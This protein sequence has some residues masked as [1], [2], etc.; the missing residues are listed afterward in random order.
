MT[1][2]TQTLKLCGCEYFRTVW[3]FL[4][5]CS[6][7]TR[8]LKCLVHFI[9]LLIIEEVN[10]NMK[11]VFWG[12]LWRLQ[13]CS[14]YFEL[15]IFNKLLQQINRYEWIVKCRTLLYKDFELKFKNLFENSNK[16]FINYIF[17]KSSWVVWADLFI[18]WSVASRCDARIIF[19]LNWNKPQFWWE[20][21][22][23]PSKVHLDFF[24]SVLNISRSPLRILMFPLLIILE[25]II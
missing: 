10:K 19:I 1:V 2:S 15:K 20:T 13:I 17:S 12:K 14:N 21:L 8:P 23:I 9:S 5:E 25:W 24:S 16:S 11:Q 6:S 18:Y 22:N 7:R 4:N 3:V